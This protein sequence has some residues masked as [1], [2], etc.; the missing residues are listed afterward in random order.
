M[1][2]F[3]N[4]WSEGKG[5]NWRNQAKAIPLQSC[6]SLIGFQ[7]F[8]YLRFLDSPLHEGGEIVS[9]RHQTP[10]PAGNISATHFFQSPSRWQDHSAV[11]S[12]MSMK[13]SSNTI[14]KRTSYLPV[15]SAL[16]QPTAPALTGETTSLIFLHK[17]I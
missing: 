5:L 3:E 16:P 6:Y 8:E 14:R 1:A 4:Y 10:L 17:C 9:T 7:G 13:N 11:G 15:C 12:I 2:K